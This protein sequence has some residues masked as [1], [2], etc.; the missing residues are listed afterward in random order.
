[1]NND[2]TIQ[3]SEWK[4]FFELFVSPF[5]ECDKDSNKLLKI[6]EVTECIKS[7]DKFSNVIT[8][9]SQWITNMD[10]FYLKVFNAFDVDRDNQ[11]NLYDYVMLRNYNNAYDILLAK[12]SKIYYNNFEIGIHLITKN[13]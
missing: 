11:L 6:D 12:E 9:H 7:G 10:N 3:D 13:V 4:N 5:N 8:F 2:K 1:M